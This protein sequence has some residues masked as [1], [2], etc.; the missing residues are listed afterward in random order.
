MTGQ[1]SLIIPVAE[2]PATGTVFKDD[3]IKFFGSNENELL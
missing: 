1:Y 3:G 2:F